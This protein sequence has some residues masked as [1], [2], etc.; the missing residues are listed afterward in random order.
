MNPAVSLKPLVFHPCLTND[1]IFNKLNIFLSTLQPNY[2]LQFINKI[3]TYD[4]III[5]IIG[6]NY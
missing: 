1:F 6:I 5:D 4:F 2:E 3:I